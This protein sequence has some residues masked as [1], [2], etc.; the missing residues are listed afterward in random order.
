[1]GGAVSLSNIRT[2]KEKELGK[3]LVFAENC[4][5]DIELSWLSKRIGKIIIIEKNGRVVGSALCSFE[6]ESFIHFMSAE[7]W[8]SLVKLAKYLLDI[9]FET[10]SAKVRTFV[11][12][13]RIDLQRSL[14]KLGFEYEGRLRKSMLNIDGKLID[15]ISMCKW[16]PD[17]PKIPKHV[18]EPLEFHIRPYRSVDYDKILELS[19]DAFPGEDPFEDAELIEEISRDN[20]ELNLIALG[21]NGRIVGGVFAWEWAPKNA[22]IY[23]LAVLHFAQGHHVGTLLLEKLEENARCKGILRLQVDTR[24]N[25]FPAILFY[26]K[27][28]F[29]FEYR[30]ITASKLKGKDVDDAVFSKSI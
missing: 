6:E 16:T 25:N 8:D 9:A 4:R 7:D 14:T 13:N 29:E 11:P 2:A 27:N 22:W 26:L 23:L 3:I 5:P 1:M 30:E 18:V 17:I 10:C 28:G 24:V 19:R 12:A 21:K 15:S 20:P